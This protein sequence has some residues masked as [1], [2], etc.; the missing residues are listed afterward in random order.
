MRD[1]NFRVFAKTFVRVLYLVS[2]M[3]DVS[4]LDQERHP[5]VQRMLSSR[6]CW[7]ASGLNG[8]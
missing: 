6:H 3:L 1:A 7:A 5:E 4:R 8:A 2:G